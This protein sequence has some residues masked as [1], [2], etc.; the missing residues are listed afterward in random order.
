ML[1]AFVK[2]LV[3]VFVCGGVTVTPNST[4]ASG[5]TFRLQTNSNLFWQLKKKIVAVFLAL[6]GFNAYGAVTINIAQAGANVVITAN[7]S[8]K[9]PSASAFTISGTSTSATSLVNASAGQGIALIISNL[10]SQP[11]ATFATSCSAGS[12]VNGL[13]KFVASG[14]VTTSPIVVNEA[15]PRYFNLGYTGGINI[16]IATR[17]ANG[18]AGVA[19]TTINVISRMTISNKTLA[20]MGI[21][22]GQSATCTWGGNSIDESIIIQTNGTPSQPAVSS[23]TPNSGTTAGGTSVTISGTNFVGTTGVSFG[24]TAATGWVVNNAYTGITINTPAHAAG[25]ADV[26]VTTVGGSATLTG[27]YTFVTP[28]LPTITSLATT[29]GPAA[30]GTSVVITGTNF[31]GATAVSFGGTAAT[32]YAVNSSTQ[33]TATTAAH[34]AGATAVA[35]TTAGGTA[36]SAA[37]F[38]YLASTATLQNLSLSTGTLSP[39]FASG[40][41][42]YTA[43]VSNATTSITVTPTVTDSNATVK[44]NTVTVS[45]GSAS[46]AIA[47]NVGA[48]TIT[49]VVTAQDGTT[50]QTY[51]TT[52]T[53][54]GA[55][56]AALS[57]LVL[58][59]GTLS[60]TFAGGTTSYTATVGNATSTI[61]VTPTVSD[62]N[63][64]VKVNTVT[65]VSGSASGS[66]AL[67]VG[68]NTITTVVTAQDGTTTSSSSWFATCDSPGHKWGL[69]WNFGTSGAHRS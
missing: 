40:T 51:T 15:S 11:M 42:S 59:S 31:T 65:V 46:G 57:N 24:G 8:M 47:L 32:S 37:A 17:D 56:N 3:D 12:G 19:D 33:I 53:R 23:I 18:V 49:T 55:N 39:T 62:S 35:V 28:A 64:T 6:V 34:A 67:N 63:A 9:L 4:S 25:A 68:S 14:V 26:V 50:T 61:T 66:I 7:G 60:P 36:T 58:S 2:K 52:V 38:T 27:G 43:S 1:S 44:V 48:N 22:D 69:K 16:P 29:S 41:T 10:N 5:R 45:S 30:G 20:Q 21:V 54:A 13:A